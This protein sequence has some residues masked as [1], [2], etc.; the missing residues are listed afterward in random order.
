[1][2][3]SF[4]EIA[5]GWNMSP[6]WKNQAQFQKH[7]VLSMPVYTCM[8]KVSSSTSYYWYRDTLN[9]ADQIDGPVSYEWKISASILT[10]WTIVLLAMVKG[11]KRTGKV[12]TMQILKILY[13]FERTHQKKCIWIY[14]VI[15]AH[16]FYCLVSL[17][18]ADSVYSA[19]PHATEHVRRTHAFVQTRCKKTYSQ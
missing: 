13:A 8:L 17:C 18:G 11:I 4:I 14:C 16:I 6:K 7:G 12:G 5:K 3:Q 9:I 10:A 1:M 15:S 19:C 2:L